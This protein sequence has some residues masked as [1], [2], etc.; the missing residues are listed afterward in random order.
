MIII[1][2]LWTQRRTILALKYLYITLYVRI[3]IA[4]DTNIKAKK[5]L[6]S[7]RPIPSSRQ[8]HKPYK[9]GETCLQD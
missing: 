4:N 2:L 8:Q 9:E 7:G 5:V 1:N 3:I 6:N